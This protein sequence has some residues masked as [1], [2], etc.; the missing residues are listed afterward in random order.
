MPTLPTPLTPVAVNV[1]IQEM[2]ISVLG[3]PANAFDQVRVDWQ[4]QGQ[5]FQ[6]IADDICYLRSVEEDDEYNR[7]RDLE[8]VF[9]DDDTVTVITSYTRIWRTFWTLYG[10]NSFDRARML[11]SALFKDVSHDAL[12]KYSLYLVTDPAAPI[13]VPEYEDGQWWERVDFS[14]QF[15]EAVVEPET[16]GFI[17]SVEVIVQSDAGVIADVITEQS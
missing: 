10:P 15:N 7:V 9:N 6:G 17:K 5:P 12:A 14:A 2:T 13:R 3:L 1:I 16:T 8:T 11:R 4:T